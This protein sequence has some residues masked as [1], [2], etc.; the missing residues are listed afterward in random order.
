MTNDIGNILFVPV[1]SI[2]VKEQV[3]RSSGS[4]SNLDKRFTFESNA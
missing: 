3:L 1:L 4:Y 2:A